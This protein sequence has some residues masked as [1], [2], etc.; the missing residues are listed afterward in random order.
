MGYESK[1]YVV[2]K[3]K[4]PTHNDKYKY[5]QV[6]AM[7][8]LCKV[9]LHRSQFR[10]TEYAFYADDGNTLVTED[11]YGDSIGELTI[12]EMIKII[13]EKQTD[14][15]GYRRWKP[16]LALLKSFDENEWEGLAV[17]HYGY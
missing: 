10:D 14:D 6:I 1:L 4:V 3:T 12:S 16:C 9:G 11:C 8:D 15:P 7:F 5:A 13:E 17:L 2:E